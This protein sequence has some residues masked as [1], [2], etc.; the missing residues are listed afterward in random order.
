MGSNPLG[1]INLFMP[2]HAWSAL[3][4]REGIKASY[5][6]LAPHSLQLKVL[7]SSGKLI[8]ELDD[9]SST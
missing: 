9:S 4:V 3:H 5:T 7:A 6:L 1:T 2:S 8:E